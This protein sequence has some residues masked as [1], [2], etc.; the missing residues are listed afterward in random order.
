[1]SAA[2]ADLLRPAPGLLGGHVAGRAEDRLGPRQAAVAVQALGQAEVGELGRLVGGQQDVGRLEVAVDDAQPCASCTARAIVSISR[3]A[4]SGGQGVPSSRAARLPPSMYS[5]SMYGRPS[6]S[7]MAWIWTMF[8]CRS[9]ATVSASARNRSADL[10]R[11]VVARQDRLEGTGAV[12]PHLPGEV[13]DPHAAA[14]ELAEHLVAGDP[15]QGGRSASRGS[16]STGRPRWMQLLRARS[17]SIVDSTRDVSSRRRS[18]RRSS[19][20][21]RRIVGDRGCPDRLAVRRACSA[22]RSPDGPRTGRRAARPSGETGADTRRAG[23]LAHLLAEDDLVVDQVED[24]VVAAAQR[25]VLLE[26][27]PRPRPARP[28]ASAARDRRSA[29]RNPPRPRSKPFPRPARRNVPRCSALPSLR[30]RLVSSRPLNLDRSRGRR[31]A[32]RARRSF[33]R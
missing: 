29:R 23:R 1:M 24:R 3:A 25:R 30:F 22:T 2:G 31:Q 5:S 13:D 7:P 33:S 32:R 28:G 20:G 12:Q 9:R 8:G 16:R 15:G 19:T 11:G 6:W 17:N 14:A 21:Q 26:V 18:G 27:V 4:R 10:G